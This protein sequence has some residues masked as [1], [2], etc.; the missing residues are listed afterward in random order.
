MN[1]E[2]RIGIGISAFGFY[3]DFIILKECQ[4]LLFFL[5]IERKLLT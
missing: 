3:L 4:A 5:V 1:Y 2:L